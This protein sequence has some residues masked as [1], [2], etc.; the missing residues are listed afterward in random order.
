MLVVMIL[1]IGGALLSLLGLFGAVRTAIGISRLFL[2]T[3]AEVTAD[4]FVLLLFLAVLTGGIVMIFVGNRKRIEIRRQT[5]HRRAMREVGAGKRSGEF[6][7]LTTP[8]NSLKE[9]SGKIL[10]YLFLEKSFLKTELQEILAT[11][12]SLSGLFDNTK[13]VLERR[14]SSGLTAEKYQTG[15]NALHKAVLSRIDMQI[16]QLCAVNE[17]GLLKKA[18]QDEECKHSLNKLIAYI[19]STKN[20]LD[21]TVGLVSRLAL[22]AIDCSV[23]V[24]EAETVRITELV[25]EINEYKI[26]P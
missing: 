21:K 1:F 11:V 4:V 20:L 6:E 17:D 7:K 14:F 24:L 2:P 23:D 12:N 10:T 16:Y 5:E 8:S 18:E 3:P 22:E 25:K 9:A 19:T 26:V 13:A 15:L